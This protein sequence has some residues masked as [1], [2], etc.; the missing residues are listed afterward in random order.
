MVWEGKGVEAASRSLLAQTDQCTVG[1]VAAAAVEEAAARAGRG[2]KPGGTN[3]WHPES[4][5]RG[6]GGD[7][8]GNHEWVWLAVAEMD[9]VQV[10]VTHI[11]PAVAAYS[12]AHTDGLLILPSAVQEVPGDQC[13]RLAVLP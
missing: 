9:R 10:R 12:S 11:S 2:W 13:C 5:L 6:F 1:I 7:G 8:W 3:F 4:L